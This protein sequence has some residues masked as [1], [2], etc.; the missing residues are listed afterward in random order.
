[1][2]K[3][4]WS[5]ILFFF[6]GISF[7]QEVIE[8]VT[9][10][11][12][13][14]A[15]VSVGAQQFNLYLSLLQ[16]KNVAI[17]ANQTSVIG[18]INTADSL[19]SLGVSLKKIFSPEHGFRGNKDAGE[20]FNN[21]KDKKTGLNV[22]S[23][24]GDHFKPSAEDLKN[25]DVVVYDLQDV[26]V[27][28]YTY[29]STL[30]Y[31]ME[32][33]AENHVKLIV[34]DRPNPNGYFVDGPVLDIKYKSFV[35]LDPVPI[36]Y[37]MTA[38]EYAQM[39]NGEGWLPNAEKCDLTC[40]KVK[41]YSHNDWYQLP[42]KPSPNL[43]NMAAVYLYPSLALFEGTVISVAR[44]TDFPFQAIGNPEIKDA[45]F[46]FTPKSIDGES[47]DPPFENQ[48]CTGY[49]LRNFGEVF[50]KNYQKMYL[51]WIEGMYKTYPDKKN[52]FNSYFNSLAGNDVLKEQI[53]K[54]MSEDD[55]RKTW[56]PALTIFKQIRKKYLLYPDFTN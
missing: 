34:L 45:P 33:C 16:G 41:N 53:I 44:G 10:T 52:F 7:A 18:K 4:F 39:L 23:L 28:F 19:I 20:N 13:T 31:V 8:P 17:V 51:Y 25:I 32:A 29:I 5:G 56:Q 48:K 14:A 9:N 22:V 26:G 1:M 46:S 3:Y 21:S 6:F 54:G 40:I 47:K 37:G 49:D 42:V 38:A 24:Y 43:P 30:H 15:D 12:K 55:I 35:G 36:V 11:V 2:K 27:R 50:M